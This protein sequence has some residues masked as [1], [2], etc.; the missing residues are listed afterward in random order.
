[1]DDPWICL[2]LGMVRY[3]EGVHEEAISYLET[4]AKGKAPQCR[5]LANAY[6]ALEQDLVIIPVINKI[7]LP[8]ADADRVV[9]QIEE[10]LG[11]DG[12]ECL[13]V[14]AKEGVGIDER[15]GIFGQV[16]LDDLR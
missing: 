13:L 4:A 2:S 3:R 15:I 1:M 16:P 11:L 8:S 10:V 5:A 7:D 12:E 14:S 9:S 6:L